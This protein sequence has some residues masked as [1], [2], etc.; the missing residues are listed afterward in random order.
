[1]YFSVCRNYLPL[2]K[3]GPFIWTNLIPLYPRM[4]CTKF[5]RNWP[6]GSGEE[7]E[8]VNVYDNNNDDDNDD[9]QILIGNEFSEI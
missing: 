8:N 7:N 3:G 5:G 4:L 1:M 6:G 9:G 2:E